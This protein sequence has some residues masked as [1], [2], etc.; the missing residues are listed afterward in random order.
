MQ[1]LI[2]YRRSDALIGR[3]T[4]YKMALQDEEAVMVICVGAVGVFPGHGVEVCVGGDEQDALRCIGKSA[5]SRCV[6]WK[7]SSVDGLAVSD[8]IIEWLCEPL[9]PHEK[10]EE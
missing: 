1:S 9:L 8:R 10:G 6:W 4:T 5:L 7:E 2:E 3:Q